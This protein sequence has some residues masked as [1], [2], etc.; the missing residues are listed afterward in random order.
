ML[1]DVGDEFRRQLAKITEH[2]IVTGELPPPEPITSTVQ[3]SGADQPALTTEAMQAV[4]EGMNTLYNA[5]KRQ[6][7]QP[8]YV[9][10]CASYTGI[11][12]KIIQP[13][14]GR[15]LIRT[16][17]VEFE[18]IGDMDEIQVYAIRLPLLTV[19]RTLPERLITWQMAQPDDSVR[20]SITLPTI[21]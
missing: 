3:S 10:V 11:I 4:L 6:A 20:F 7:D 21:S 9:V 17:E 14:K 16:Q 19:S 15:V 2:L 8:Q 12:Q 18:V 13:A 5:E 1:F